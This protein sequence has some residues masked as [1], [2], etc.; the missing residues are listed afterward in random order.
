[1]RTITVIGS[2]NIDLVVAAEHLPR[3]GETVLGYDYR[4]T[5]G[6]KG[7]NQAVAAARLGGVVS[8]VGCVGSDEHG[9]LA[10]ANLEKQGVGVRAV[11][12]VKSASTGVALIVV[13]S[14]GRNLIAV[15]PNANA[16]VRV[17]KH[18]FD[19]VV[20]QLETPYAL[21]RARLFILNPAPASLDALHAP[22]GGPNR[23][24]TGPTK[25]GLQIGA[26]RSARRRPQTSATRSGR[27]RPLEG[28][29]VVVPNEHEAATLT[30]E[31]APS[32]AARELI[33]MG[34]RRAIVTLG[35]RGVYDSEEA[36]IQPAFKIQVVDTV[37]AGDAFVG[38]LAMALAQGRCDAVRFAQAAAA[39][40][41][42][43]PGAQ[44]VPSRAEIERLLG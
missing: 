36:R 38:A 2:I 27:R 12:C 33:R 37:G 32:A 24:Q 28:V 11:R 17:P 39:L 31:H 15:A 44:N 10:R 25:G 40:K 26:T 23:L 41:C 21:P 34:A 35:E 7:A 5:F 22:F 13:D 1:M 43:R 8:M 20:M 16:R 6:G 3:P 19:V 14:R 18:A 4:M 42:T 29:D 9:R 30:G